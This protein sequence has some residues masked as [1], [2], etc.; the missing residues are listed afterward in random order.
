MT[1]KRSIPGYM[2]GRTTVAIH[3]KSAEVVTQR[4][5]RSNRGMMQEDT[6]FIWLVMR[7]TELLRQ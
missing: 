3:G 2:I 1:Q 5:F 4:T 6:F 7:G